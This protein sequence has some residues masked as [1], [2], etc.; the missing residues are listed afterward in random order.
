MSDFV[1]AAILSITVV[2]DG[3]EAEVEDGREAE[4]ARS[5]DGWF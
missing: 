3:R 2:E 1:K 4:A 5:G